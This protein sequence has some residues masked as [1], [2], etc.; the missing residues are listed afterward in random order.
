MRFGS[1]IKNKILEAMSMGMVVI[2]TKVSFEGI[3]CT[4]GHDCVLVEVDEHK[5]A[6]AVEEI[7]QNQVA[8]TSMRENARDLAEKKY[9]WDSIRK[10]YGLIY[11]NRF[12]N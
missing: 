2:G 4:P 3:E 9:S 8:Y 6:T 12:S 7:F 1:G 10:A 11:E 5:M